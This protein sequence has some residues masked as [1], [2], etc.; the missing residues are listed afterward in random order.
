ML[1]GC[2][3]ARC[4]GGAKK[5]CRFDQNLEDPMYGQ[6]LR[7]TGQELVGTQ[8]PAGGTPQDCL[9]MNLMMLSLVPGALKLWQQERACEALINTAAKLQ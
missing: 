7:A 8:S 5:N 9:D 1:S 4:Q 3:M 6:A 2:K